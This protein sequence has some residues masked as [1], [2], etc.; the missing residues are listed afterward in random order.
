MPTAYD[1]PVST[2]NIINK[3]NVDERCVI[4][5][6]ICFP[7]QFFLQVFFVDRECT[8]G[9]SCGEQIGVLVQRGAKFKITEVAVRNL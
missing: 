8:P 2:K 4:V 1:R 5:Q 9:W 6:F 7:A 3:Q